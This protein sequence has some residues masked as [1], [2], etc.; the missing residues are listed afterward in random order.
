M[1]SDKPA[2]IRLSG[3]NILEEHCW[4]EHTGTRVTLTAAPD[5]ITVHPLLCYSQTITQPSLNSFSTASKF[6][7]IRFAQNIG[8]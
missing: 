5:S 4:F 8:L 2:A 1:D 7:L 3:N 6:H